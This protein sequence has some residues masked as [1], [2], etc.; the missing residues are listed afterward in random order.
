MRQR[1]AVKHPGLQD[2][3][4]EPQDPPVA[5]PFLDAVQDQIEPQPVEKALDVGINHPHP[6]LMHRFPHGPQG[7]VR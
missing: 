1:L 4:D 6:A 2:E 5:H 3:P 7:L